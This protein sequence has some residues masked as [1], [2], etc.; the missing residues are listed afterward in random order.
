MPSI[1]TWITG[2][3]GSPVPGLAFVMALYLCAAA[4]LMHVLRHKPAYA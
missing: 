3:T 2:A 1:T 4:L